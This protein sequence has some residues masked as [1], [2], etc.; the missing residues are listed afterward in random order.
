MRPGPT[1]LVSP[2]PRWPPIS[3]WRICASCR[4]S[5]RSADRT[6][7]FLTLKSSCSQIVWTET[8]PNR[9]LSRIGPRR[10]EILPFLKERDSYHRD[11]AAISVVSCCR[12][13]TSQ[14]RRT[15]I[16]KEACKAKSAE[17][18]QRLGFR[19]WEF[20]IGRTSKRR[21]A[22]VG[23]VKAF[24]AESFAL[25]GARALRID[26]N[27]PTARVLIAASTGRNRLRP[28][29]D[30]RNDGRYWPHVWTRCSEPAGSGSNRAHRKV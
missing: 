14:F 27:L 16:N 26:A 24:P 29:C 10:I 13:L 19:S 22:I 21:K 9:R 17:R 11:H 1:T 4:S 25:K 5:T 8:H 7:Q 12:P 20:T 28:R 2:G 15:C 30:Q 23:T 18:I 6:V 3:S